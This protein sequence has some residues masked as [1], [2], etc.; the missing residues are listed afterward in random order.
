MKLPIKSKQQTL[1]AHKG[2]N[3]VPCTALNGGDDFGMWGRE[4]KRKKLGAVGSDQG[5]TRERR[6]VRNDVFPIV[7]NSRQLVTNSSRVLLSVRPGVLL[8]VVAYLS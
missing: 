1:A 2:S 8:S 3:A 7:T 6:C 4:W 5:M